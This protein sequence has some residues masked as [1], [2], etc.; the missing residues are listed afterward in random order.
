MDMVYAQRRL[1]AGETWLKRTTAD[2]FYRFMQSIGRRTPLPR[3]VGDFRLMSRRVLDAVLLLREHHRFMKGVFAWV[4]YPSEAILYDRE[5]RAAGDTKWSFWKLWNLAIDG[6]TSY[7]VMPLKASTYL[8]LIV[9][10]LALIYGGQ[11]IL[12]TI[13][14]GNPVPGYPSLLVTVLFM[15]GVQLITLG[16]MGEYLGRIF[17]ETKHRPLYLVERYQPAKSDNQE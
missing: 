4:G 7:T 15:G 14:L 13:I 11:M 1:R 2:L 17:N 5:A 6:I 3:N 12:R 9:A 10:V 8:G 16:I